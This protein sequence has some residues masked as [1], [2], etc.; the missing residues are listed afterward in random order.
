MKLWAEVNEE[1]EQLFNLMEEVQK[2]LLK[3]KADTG[4]A[5]EE[6]DLRLCSWSDDLAETQKTAQQWKARPE[7]QEKTMIFINKV[8]TRSAALQT[9][10]GLLPTGDYGSR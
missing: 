4:Y 7:K 2:K 3:R 8:G 10:L 5:R 1:K 9:W 6:V